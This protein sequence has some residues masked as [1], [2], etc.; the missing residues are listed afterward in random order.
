MS[1]YVVPGV[2]GQIK[3]TTLPSGDMSVAG[4]ASG[5]LEQIMLDVC[6]WTGQRNPDYGGWIVPRA[7]IGRVNAALSSRC[8]KIAD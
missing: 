1:I 4:P 6:R 2:Q 5:P 3:T 7:A 8:S